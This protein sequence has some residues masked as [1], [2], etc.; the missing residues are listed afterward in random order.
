MRTLQ[1]I[2]AHLISPSSS[3]PSYYYYHYSS[4]LRPCAQIASDGIMPDSAI[5]ARW[6]ACQAYLSGQTPDQTVLVTANYGGAPIEANVALSLVA[7]P[8]AWFPLLLHI[9]AVE[10]YV[11]FLF[12]AL[13]SLFTLVVSLP[14]PA[15]LRLLSLNHFPLLLC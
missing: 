6:P 4:S 5:A 12:W 7:G 15:F 13:S 3:T 10:V 9:V 1:Q 8:A 11:R 2:G 14:F